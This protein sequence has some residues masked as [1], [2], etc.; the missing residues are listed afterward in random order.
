MPRKVAFS[1]QTPRERENDTR[2]QR[3]TH[4]QKERKLF[5]SSRRVSVLVYIHIY[6]YLEREREREREKDTHA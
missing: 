6:V 4:T 1:I 2:E 3:L 5:S